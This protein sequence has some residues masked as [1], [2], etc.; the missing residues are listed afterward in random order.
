M[1]RISALTELTELASNDYL[2]VLDSSANIAK[3]I[4]VA[5]AFGIPDASWTAAGESW[6]YASATTLTVPTDATIKYDEGMVIRFTQSTGG[7]KYAVITNVAATVLTIAMLNGATLVNEAITSTQ[8]SS[9]ASPF[10]AGLIN[11]NRLDFSKTGQGGIW[12][13]ELGRT[14]LGSN[15]DTISVTNL[16]A[17]KYLKILISVVGSGNINLDMK[18]NGDTANNYVYRRSINGGAEDPQT[19]QGAIQLQDSSSAPPMFSEVE[20][21]NIS[22]QEKMIIGH[23]IRQNTAGAGNIPAR[24]EVV[25]KWANTSAQISRVDLVNT[26][27]GDFVAGS[28]VIVLGHN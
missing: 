24:V 23:T 9:L 8:Y 15:G 16:P 5:N 19:S 14:T 7:T 27:A 17:R 1:G 21:L 18:F 20:A 26:L 2:V 3:K 6:T 28:E 25:G 13:E 11:G 4:S 10:G 12:W 22:A